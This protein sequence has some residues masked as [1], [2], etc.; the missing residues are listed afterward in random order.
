MESLHPGTQVP[1][2]KGSPMVLLLALLVV[3]IVAGLGFTLHLL[4]VLA[5]VMLVL[6]IIG[7][8]VG[9][10]ENAGSRHFYRW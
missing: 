1:P 4:W 6:W 7:F 2:T 9:R 5:A 10:G 3:L 8:A